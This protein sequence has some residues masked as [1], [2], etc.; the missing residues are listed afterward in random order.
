M[1]NNNSSKYL[2]YWGVL[3]LILSFT[4]CEK[5]PGE[6]G[7][8]SITGKVMTDEYLN[9][10]LV[11]DTYA[12]SEQRVYII[13]G[14]AEGEGFDDD[15]RTSYDGSYKFDYLRPGDYRIFTYSECV[16]GDLTCPSGQEAVFHDITIS[17]NSD[18]QDVEDLVSREYP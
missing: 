1:S 16:F 3:L 18:E 9:Q 2:Y 11:L 17:D 15:T 8:G 4:A 6:G 13:Y 12:A 10:T 14:G 7:G 5:A